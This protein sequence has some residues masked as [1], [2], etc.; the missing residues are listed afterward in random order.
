[1]DIEQENNSNI[2]DIPDRE[3]IINAILPIFVNIQ[4]H[5]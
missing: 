1:M 5:L 3:N 4:I 2:L